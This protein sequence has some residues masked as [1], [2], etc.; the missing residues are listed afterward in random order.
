MPGNIVLVGFMGSGKT[1]VG[2]L[3]ALRLGWPFVDTDELI[4]DREGISIAEIFSRYGEAYFRQQERRVIEEL[5]SRRRT[6]I[7]T[8]GGAFIPKDSRE[9]LKRGNR[10]V[11][12]RVRPETV[13]KRIG[14]SQDRPLLL[15]LSLAQVESLLAQRE[16]FYAE[17][18]IHLEVDGKDPEEVAREIE[19]E[20]K[21][22]LESSG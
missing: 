14:G 1:Q 12:L 4:E 5:A 18:H 17:A 20:L 22:W 2:K 10:V 3:L 9:I 7:A 19:E 6:V 13:L 11:W 8:G 21:Q 16:P 15:G